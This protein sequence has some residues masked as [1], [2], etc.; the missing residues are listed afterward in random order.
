MCI[1]HR[2][3][4]LTKHP[5]QTL[6]IRDKKD[7]F[8][9]FD[10]RDILA[11]MGSRAVDACWEISDVASYGEELDATG[12][13]AG[14]L[15]SLAIS[16]TRIAGAELIELAKN[17]SQVIWGEFRAYDERRADTPWAIIR[18]IDSSFYEVS[19]SDPSVIGQIRATFA[20]VRSL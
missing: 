4:L 7:H 18:A 13:G 1:F 15:E 12:D 6:Q 5:M 19:S 9:T 10:L 14:R 16:T 2:F 20:D 11:E 8:L 3:Y 17:I